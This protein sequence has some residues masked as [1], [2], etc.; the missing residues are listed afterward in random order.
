MDRAQSGPPEIFLS[1]TSYAA[2][3][4]VMSVIYRPTH[5]PLGTAELSP[6]TPAVNARGGN[7]K[8]PST[9]LHRTGEPRRPGFSFSRRTELTSNRSDSAVDLAC[10]KTSRCSRIRRL[11]AT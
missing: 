3:I 5:L 7:G 10:C 4:R 11:H 8:I 1:G 2:V 9:A 6:I